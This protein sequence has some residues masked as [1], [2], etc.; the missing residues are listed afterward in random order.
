MQRQVTVW[1]LEMTDPGQLVPSRPLPAHTRLERVGQP[2]PELNRGLYA[3]VGG[4]LFWIDRLAWDY[5]RWMDWLDRPELETWLLTDDGAPA[6]YFELE[7]QPATG[8]VELASFGL[9]PAWVGRGLGG[10]LLEAALRRAW[11]LGPRR[12]WLHTCSLD[13]PSARAAYEK[14]GLRLFDTQQQ[15]Q[16]LP[17]DSPGPWPGAQRV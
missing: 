13:H 4:D 7:H 1:H 3:A 14:R 17:D 2:S 5:S 16:E 12:V 11:S 10:A 8:S 9:L 6:G 15:L